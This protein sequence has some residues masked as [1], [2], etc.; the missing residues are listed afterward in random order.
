MFRLILL[1]RCYLGLLLRDNLSIAIL[2]DLGSRVCGVFGIYADG[3]NF[4]KNLIGSHSPPS[5]RQFRSSVVQAMFT[6]SIYVELGDGR[7]ALFWT[8]RWLQG[9]SLLDLAPCLCNTIGARVK[10]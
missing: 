6:A 7:K 9:Q 4:E 1:P 2:T 8:D 3:S 5:G 10:K